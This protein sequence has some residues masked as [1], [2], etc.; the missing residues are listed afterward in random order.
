MRLHRPL[1]WFGFAALTLTVVVTGT[2][3]SVGLWYQLKLP[4]PFRT[5]PAGLAVVFILATVFS[6]ATR[7]RWI[8]MGVFFGAFAL[9]LGW[10]GTIT[11]KAD[12]NWS[13]DVAR[14]L[15]A[16]LDGDKAVLT[17]VRNFTWRSDTDF[18][19]VWEVR[20]YDLATIT[21]VDLIMSYWMGEAIAHT[22]VSF[23]FADG[24]RLAFSI[25]TRKEAHEQYSSIAGFFKQ[26]ELVI[27]AADERDVVK[28]RSNIRGEDVRLYRLRVSR[29][30]AR[31]LFIEYLEQAND[32]ARSPRF[33]NT[34]TSNCTTLVFDMVRVI[35]PG[36]PLDY[37]VVLAGYLPD[38]AYA[39]GALDTDLPFERLRDLAKIHDKAIRAGS[40]PDF[41]KLIRE[42]IP[43]PT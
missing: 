11:P 33:Y 22:I 24:Q 32:L 9:F 12:R 3:C 10:W 43:K 36:L 21:D 2:W 18:D 8:G 38:Y 30:D 34:A 23:G 40:N 19:P 39:V 16:T 15:T 26:Y 4:G 17:N 14:S 31:Q 29:E 35:H 42:G 37:R 41:P 5:V 28:V 6:L 7:K 20:T 1:R 27:I 13:P 25:E